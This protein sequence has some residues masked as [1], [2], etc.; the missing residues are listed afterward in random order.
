MF[1]EAVSTIRENAEDVGNSAIRYYG[2]MVT[3]QSVTTPWAPGATLYGWPVAYA[4]DDSPVGNA[5]WP[6]WEVREVSA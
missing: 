4:N 2:S 1:Q 3:E 6:G 5:R